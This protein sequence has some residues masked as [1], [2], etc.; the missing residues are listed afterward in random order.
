MAT[1]RK[2]KDREPPKV[3][4][5]GAKLIDQT[6]AARLANMSPATLRRAHRMG[7]GPPRYLRAGGRHPFYIDTE[8]GAWALT[9][10][11]RQGPQEATG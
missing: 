11:E 10:A 4:P 6:E 3:L 8:V 1:T 2:R 5:A 9:R 7:D